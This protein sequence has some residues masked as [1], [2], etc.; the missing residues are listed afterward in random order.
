MER[1]ALVSDIHGNYPAWQAVLADIDQRGIKRIF[2]LGDLV[3]KGPD[4][5]KITDEVAQR[6]EVIIRGNWEELVARMSGDDELFGW[7]AQQ[8][9]P[10]R[11]KYLEELPF[12]HEFLLSG[13]W[14]SLVHASPE[15][16]FHRVQPWDDLERR[17][18]MFAPV[19]NPT[20]QESIIPDI[21]G[22]G[23]IHN[24]Y[25]QHLEGR[26]LFNT[27]SVGNPL[28]IPAASYAILEGEYLSEEIAPYSLQ[29]ARVPYDIEQAVQDARDANIP[30]LDYYIKELRTGVY[31]AMQQD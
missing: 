8:L 23:D 13:R 10:E 6:C 31:R 15:N 20:T 12:R 14:V 25:M 7:Q 11:V 29:F 9:G 26:L 18:G 28:D 17:L 5:V 4:A 27:G 19:V 24:A 1:I 3:G 2:C 16:V 22:Y 21:V 30:A